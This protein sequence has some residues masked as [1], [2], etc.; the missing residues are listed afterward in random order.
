MNMILR[1]H[2]IIFFTF[3]AFCGFYSLL[4]E[5][6]PPTISGSA[7][8]ACIGASIAEIIKNLIKQN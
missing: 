6:V 7:Y 2:A 4:A 8:G 3:T 5:Y 1:I